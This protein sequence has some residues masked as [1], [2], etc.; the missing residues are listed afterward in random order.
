[1]LDVPF[2]AEEVTNTVCRLNGRKAAGPDGLVT[3]H[4]KAE[5][6]SVVIWLRNILNPLEV[7]PDI[8]K[9]SLG[10]GGEWVKI[11]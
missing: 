8:L 7:V 2:S 10:M 9:R 11:P 5:G 6:E 1:M 3:Q 4:L